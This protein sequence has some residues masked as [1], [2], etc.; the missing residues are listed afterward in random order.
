MFH[1][2]IEMPNFDQHHI[3]QH[4]KHLFHQQD[5]N[6]SLN[7]NQQLNHNNM[8]SQE[9]I[10]PIQSTTNHVVSRLISDFNTNQEH[11]RVLTTTEVSS[12]QDQHS[13]NSNNNHHIEH[14]ISNTQTNE[15]NHMI[16]NQPD[17]SIV[18][19]EPINN[20]LPAQIYDNYN[21]NQVF[22]HGNQPITIIQHQNDLRQTNQSHLH[23]GDQHIVQVCNGQAPVNE[24]Q[25]SYVDLFC[26]SK[27]P[28]SEMRQDQQLTAEVANINQTL[29][30]YIPISDLSK[31][32]QQSPTNFQL[33]NSRNTNYNHACVHNQA[34]TI[35][36]SG[37]VATISNVPP[38][39]NNQI[40]HSYNQSRRHSSITACNSSLR[41]SYKVGKGKGNAAINPSANET[42]NFETIHQ[43]NTHNTCSNGQIKLKGSSSEIRKTFNCPTCS[44]VF[45]EKFN[46]KRHMQIHSQSRPKY[47]C[48]ECSKSFAWKDNFIRHKKAAHISTVNI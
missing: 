9:S 32:D 41:C 8:Q 19:L 16:T 6:V 47:V 24:A 34:D 27:T 45:T 39:V 35:R 26:I 40:M 48:N 10:E 33:K 36:I 23:T 20:I 42:N 38:G 17:N 44:K 4:N 1:D 28:Y 22:V 2:D 21:D 43:Y 30:N 5:C 3:Q 29:V 13:F 37:N 15:R 14:T 25:P 12:V 31:N 18:H 11:P 46:M 7:N